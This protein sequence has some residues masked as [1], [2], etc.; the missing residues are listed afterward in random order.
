MKNSDNRHVLSDKTEN[1]YTLP[2]DAYNF[3]LK[4]SNFKY[5]IVAYYGLNKINK[6]QFGLINKLKLLDR[7]E[8]YAPKTP[9]FTFKDHKANF[10]SKLTVRL[11]CP[12]KPDLGRIN[13]PI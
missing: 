10:E 4:E 5:K 7:M 1:Q 9:H 13:K 2:D 3:I 6:K 12:T 8:P 11:I